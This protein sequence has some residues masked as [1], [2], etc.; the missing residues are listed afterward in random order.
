VVDNASTDNSVAKLRQQFPQLHIIANSE[1]V[2][3]ARAVNQGLKSADAADYYLLLNPD[4]IIPI[5]PHLTPSHPLDVMAEFLQNHTE[6]GAVGCRLLLADGT[7]QIST[8]CFPSPIT[9][10]TDHSLLHPLRIFWRRLKRKLRGKNH[11]L[12]QNL[13]AEEVDWLMGACI[14]LPANTMREV[15]YLD[16]QFF[17]YAE[18]ADL[19]YRIRQTGKKIYYLPDVFIYHFHKGTSRK[20]LQ[21][22]FVQLFRSL[23]LYHYKHSSLLNRLTIRLFI[24]VDM[25]IRFFIYGLLWTITFGR[26]TEHR[27]RLKATLQVIGLVIK[28][29]PEKKHN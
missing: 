21:F 11:H 27:Q 26:K 4:T 23:L 20:F 13:F 24:L 5:N 16:E 22:T 28:F 14:L 8:G 29:S 15:G 2:G 12:S 6:A 3:F 17:M 25:I 19:C 9:Y 7:T 10:L 18:D 1:N